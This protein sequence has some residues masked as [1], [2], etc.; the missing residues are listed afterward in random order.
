MGHNEAEDVPYE[1]L[2]FLGKSHQAL[3]EYSDAIEIYNTAVSRFGVNVDLLNS[4]G[5]CSFRL[6]NNEDALDA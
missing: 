3:S 5:E 6:G 4:L 1:I 2:L